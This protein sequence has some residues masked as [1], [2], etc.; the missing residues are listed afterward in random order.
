MRRSFPR[1]PEPEIMDLAHEAEVY[2]HADFSDVNE[3]FVKRLVELDGQSDPSRPLLAIDLGTG[4]ADIPVRLLRLRPAWRIVAADASP[5]MLCFAGETL[6]GEER[7]GNI[8][9]LLVDVKNTPFAD[10]TFDV[11]FSNS[12]LHHI[13]DTATFWAE[14]MRIARPGAFVLLRD[15]A[16][17]ASSEEALEIV[18]RYA[19]LGTD[20]LQEEY[21]R[22]LLS[23]WTVDEVREQLRVAGLDRLQVAMVTDRHLDISGRLPT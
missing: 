11:V 23:A 10:E 8:H 14:L 2:A 13:E 3:A 1:E 6:A 4:P 7:A 5:A 9:L 16:R 15:L 12:I 19:S 18:S 22:S 17:P 21:Y 20:M